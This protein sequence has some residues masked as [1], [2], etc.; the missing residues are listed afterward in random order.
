MNHIGSEVFWVKF[1]YWIY[2]WK[3]FNKL[4]IEEQKILTENISFYNNLS[5]K[6][7][8]KFEYRVKRFIK[9]HHF[10]GREN[11]EIDSFVLMMI[12][13]SAI[14]VTFKLNNYLFKH[15]STIL[16]YPKN[17]LSRHTKLMHKGETNPGMQAVV[18]S[19]ESLLKGI[20]IENDNLHLG[21]HEFTH[22][23]YFSY[24][25]E[26]SRESNRFISNYKKVFT[27]L[28]DK[29]QK[30]KVLKSNYFRDYAYENKHEFLAVLTENYFE[31]PI[32]FKEKLPELFGLVNKLYRIYE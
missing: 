18:L 1:F 24:E 20:K 15:F 8:K 12:A 16:V 7:K 17:F 31:T 2:G 10:I 27:L 4:N 13:S 22:A 25:K 11:L 19:F 23:L 5:V 28:A 29:T 3:I 14:I 32:E 26:Y 9:A 30:E 21:I 6:D